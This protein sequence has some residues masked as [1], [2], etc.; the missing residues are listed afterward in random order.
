MPDRTLP[1]AADIE[2]AMRGALDAAAVLWLDLH[3]LPETTS[4]MSN[5]F[6]HEAEDA[7]WRMVPGGRASLR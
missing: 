3:G 7:Y 5:R 4:T 6:L 1:D 2:R